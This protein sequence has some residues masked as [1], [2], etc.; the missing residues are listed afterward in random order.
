MN[1]DFA[2]GTTKIRRPIPMNTE[3]VIAIA[4]Y[5]GI[6]LM[7]VAAPYEVFNWVAAHWPGHADQVKVW[8]VA[9]KL[10]PVTPANRRPTTSQ[11]N[12]GAHDCSR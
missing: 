7:D 1:I 4:V 11:P 9:E 2:A 5:P 12:T 3:F 6:D 8:L 10:A